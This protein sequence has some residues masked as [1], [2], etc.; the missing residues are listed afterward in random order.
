MKEEPPCVIRIALAYRR[1][2]T[3]VQI[4]AGAPLSFLNVAFKISFAKAF[5]R[6]MPFL[7]LWFAYY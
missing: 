1:A 4:W 5:R 2:R 3:P 7:N 6:D